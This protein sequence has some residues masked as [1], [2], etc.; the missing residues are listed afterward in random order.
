MKKIFLLTFILIC[1]SAAETKSALAILRIDEPDL[2]I[3][4]AVWYA[5]M[6]RYRDGFPTEKLGSALLF[7]PALSVKLYNDFN[8]TMNMELMQLWVL[9]TIWRVFIQ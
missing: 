9:H 8:L 5:R 4:A 1:L 3:G 6:D 2:T 7:G